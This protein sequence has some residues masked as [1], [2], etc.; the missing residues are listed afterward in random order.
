MRDDLMMHWLWMQAMEYALRIAIE[1]PRQQLYPRDK[2]DDWKGIGLEKILH[3]SL[4]L[5]LETLGQD[6]SPQGSCAG[7]GHYHIGYHIEAD[8]KGIVSKYKDLEVM[9]KWPEVKKF[10]EELL[11]PSSNI[12]QL[13]LF[14]ILAQEVTHAKRIYTANP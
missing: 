10:I 3:D 14:E 4:K 11:A 6:V 2:Y 8:H 13:D 7:H 9:V 1:R 12:K 5:A